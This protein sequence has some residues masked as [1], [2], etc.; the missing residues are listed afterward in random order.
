MKLSLI[1]MNST[2]SRDDNVAKASALIDRAVASERPDLVVVPE[3]FNTLY[4]FQYW[5][6]KYLKEAERDDGPTITRMKEKA[7][8]HRIHVIA[9]IFEEDGP[10]LYYDTA[11]AIDPEG[12][13]IGKYRKTHP[14]AVR[15]L[16]KLFFRYGSHFPVFKI[17][18]WRVGAVICYDAAFPETARCSAINGAELIVAPFAAPLRNCWR[19]QM[20]VRAFEN[21]VFFA[22]C[23]KVGTE[24]NWKFGG[25]SM[26]VDPHGTVLA[27]ASGTKEEIITASLN[28]D[29]IYRARQVRPHFRDRRPDLYAPICTP[30]EDIPRLD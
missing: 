19:E 3:F 16:E 25:T 23:N 8:E 22:P 6:M 14:A 17:G 27:E 2:A 24:G 9:T 18:D 26:I 15:S 30:T 12:R 29:E 10:G 4:V 7:R 20:M 21:G 1:Q 28:R 13:I 5:D 11:I